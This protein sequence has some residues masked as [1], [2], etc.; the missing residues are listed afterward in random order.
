MQDALQG[1]TDAPAK[2]HEGFNRRDDLESERTSISGL[3]GG[4]WRLTSR[5]HG[6]GMEAEQLHLVFLA[7]AFPWLASG[8]G[9]GNGG[10]GGVGVG[11]GAFHHDK[12]RVGS[13]FRFLRLSEGSRSDDGLG[14]INERMGEY[15]D[16]GSCLLRSFRTGTPWRPLTS[17]H[18]VL[19]LAYESVLCPVAFANASRQ[20]ARRGTRIVWNQP[21]A[22][23]GEL[24]ADNGAPE[25][26]ASV[27]RNWGNLLYLNLINCCRCFVP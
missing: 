10:G 5:V 1:L 17:E 19:L 2:P 12:T 24:L 21:I 18:G 11:V 22:R 27:P 3:R 23:R 13:H 6:S 14:R 26:A 4:R 25:L 7:F 9:G 8:G 16:A 20:S 15:D